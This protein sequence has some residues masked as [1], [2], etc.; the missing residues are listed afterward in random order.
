EDGGRAVLALLDVRGVGRPDEDLPHLLG[1]GEERAPD[2]LEGD[3]VD[4]QHGG[5][6]IAPKPPTRVAPRRSG[7]AP[8]MRARWGGSTWAPFPPTPR[9]PERR[10]G[11][12]RFRGAWLT[13][14]GLDEEVCMVV[15]RGLM[16]GRDQRRGIH[17]LD[18]GR[19]GDSVAA[20]QP[21]ASI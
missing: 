1:D 14:S 16:A 21:L 13:I 12:P 9:A 5:L 18:D 20:E 17:L 11:A 2:H 15:D 7:D 6:A 19:P 4:L 10:R 3:S 8:R